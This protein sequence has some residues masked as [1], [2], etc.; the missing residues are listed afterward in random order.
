MDVSVILVNYNTKDLL[1]QCLLSIFEKTLMVTFEVIVSDNDSKDG[2]LEML[3]EEFPNVIA[4][5]NNA[6]LGFGKANNKAISVAK[7]KYLFL[8]NTDTYLL[9]NAIKILFDYMENP[10]HNRVGCC[11]GDLF[12]AR[13]GKQASFGNFP[14]VLDAISQ[15]GFYR[16]YKNYYNKHISAGAINPDQTIKEVDFICGADMFIRRTLLDQIG[17][18]DEDFF[19]YFEETE[20]SYRIKQAGF[21]SV[22]VPQAEIVHLEGGS[23][24]ME[25]FNFF[26]T[27]VFAKSRKL[28][29]KKTSGAW[30]ATFVTLIF[31]F[32]SFLLFLM[33][34][35]KN[36]LKQMVAIFKA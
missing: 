35:N 31:M 32:Q 21:K 18:F 9:N 28:Y 1:R 13:G 14:S 36:Y 34:G 7:G 30:S 3:H 19:L 10:Q 33:K 29:F 4:L 25:T 27:S 23:Q 16:F 2:S 26:K 15:I 17:A 12:D 20:L 24:G 8:L 11:G 6:N 22:L 5:Q